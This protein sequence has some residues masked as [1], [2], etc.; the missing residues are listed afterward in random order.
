MTQHYGSE[1]C[2][3]RC[4]WSNSSEAWSQATVVYEKVIEAIHYIYC[5]W[6]PKQSI[7]RAWYMSSKKYLPII[8]EVYWHRLN[9]LFP[10]FTIL[11]S[12]GGRCRNG[13][14]RFGWWLFTGQIDLA[15]GPNV[16]RF[17]SHWLIQKAVKFTVI[18]IRRPGTGHFEATF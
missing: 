4:R 17:I 1:G 7:C 6:E 10:P 2:S 16:K 15:S 3:R 8:R 18:N 11:P 14:I 5:G 9:Q 12:E 13:R